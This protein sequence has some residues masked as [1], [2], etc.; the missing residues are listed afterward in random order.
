VNSD[1]RAPIFKIASVGIVGDLYEV[2]PSL[3]R[4]L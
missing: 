2:L 3:I 1:P 4:Q